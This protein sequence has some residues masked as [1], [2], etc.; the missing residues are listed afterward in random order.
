MDRKKYGFR[1]IVVC[2]FLLAAAGAARV[3]IWRSHW[4][5]SLPLDQSLREV[6][7]WKGFDQFSGMDESVSDTLAT[8][9]TLFRTYRKADKSVGVFIGYYS[10]LDKIGKPHSPLVCFPGQGWKTSSEQVRVINIPGEQNQELRV[11]SILAEKGQQRELVVFWFQAYDRAFP[12]TFQQ[13]LGALWNKI[14][15]GREENAFVRITV[16]VEGHKISEAVADA[17]E[18]LGVFYP[19]FLRYIKQEWSLQR[20]S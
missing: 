17:S 2:L 5:K 4:E 15:H 7:G 3:S 8:D 16:G 13:K 1:I 19:A 10:T 9:E 20:C 6:G 18:F 11:N 12:G 14:R